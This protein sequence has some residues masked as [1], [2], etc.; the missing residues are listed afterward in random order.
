MSV[1]LINQFKEKGFVTFP[2]VFEVSEIEYYRLVIKEAIK[3]AILEGEIPNEK[4]A[5]IHPMSKS[6]G[7]LSYY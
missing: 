4:E 6:L 3:E 5:V 1:K 2:N 7:R